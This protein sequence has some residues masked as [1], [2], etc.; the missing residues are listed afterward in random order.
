MDTKIQLIVYQFI[1]AMKKI[2]RKKSTDIF[3]LNEKL[4]L[5]EMIEIQNL[6]ST[7][8]LSNLKEIY[9]EIEKGSIALLIF[10]NEMPTYQDMRDYFF[11]NSLYPKLLNEIREAKKNGTYDTH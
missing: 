9:T 1:G 3:R 4:G 6:I 7:I 5:D 11:P 10:K 8:N 2:L